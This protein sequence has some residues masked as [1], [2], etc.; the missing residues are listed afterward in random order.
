M[1][2]PTKFVWLDGKFVEW[3]KAQ[4]H[5]LTHSLHYGTAIFEGIRSNETH[6]G[7]AIFRLK[8]HLKR[9]YNS[10][11]IMQ[12]KVPYSFDEVFHACK[13]LVS[14]NKLD[15]CYI[16][17]LAFFGYGRM[18]IGSSDCTVNMGIAAWHWGA[19]LGQKGVENGI[20]VKVSS[21]ASHDANIV[22]TKSKTSGNYSTFT[23]AK[24][25][26]VQAGYD[27][28]VML[29][30]DGFV[31][32]GSAENIFIF[33]DNHLITP[34][35]ESIL[36]GVTRDSILQLARDFKIPVKEE[37][38]SR[39]TL[40]TADEAFLSGTAAE[41]APIIEV[42]NRVIGTGKPGHVTTKLQKKFFD[43][44]RAKDKKYYKWLEF[45]K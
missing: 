25:E 22:M 8:E 36:E 43:I 19:Y 2:T 15:S 45:V 23:L 30:P 5:F 10:A 28:A 18:G 31:S 29:D 33:R 38:F 16:R 12:M 13:E 1:I 42:D 27:E 11:K 14:M 39:D 4:V 21:Y 32:E 20:R 7:P 37:K 41:I 40:Y 9:F 6:K 17:P 26:A 44:T 35:K 24:N 3:D 34:P